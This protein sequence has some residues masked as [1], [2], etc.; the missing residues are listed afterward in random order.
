MKK[1]LSAIAAIIFAVL[2]PIACVSSSFGGYEGYFGFHS[3]LYTYTRYFIFFVLLIILTALNRNNK[4]ILTIVIPTELFIIAIWMYYDYF[5]RHQLL[6]NFSFLLWFGATVSS[7]SAG[8]LCGAT[9]SVRQHYELFYQRFWYTYTAVYLLIFYVSF[10]RT[11]DSYGLT[12]NTIPFQGTIKYFKYIFTNSNPDL[13]L[14]LVCIGN[15]FI[16]IPLPFLL[17][18]YLKKLPTWCLIIIGFIIPCC[19][20][21]YQYIFR[22]GNVDVDDLILNWLGFAIGLTVERL[23]RKN[24]L[25]TKAQE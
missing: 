12:I 24:L 6:Y 2:F 4:K 23:I 21:G 9:L 20:E 22:C 7:A 13:Y 1:I 15:I 16:F 8:I 17:T 14:T 3:M 18:N 10:I 25:T 19:V 5:I 11:P